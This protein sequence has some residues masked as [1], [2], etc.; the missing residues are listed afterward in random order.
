MKYNQNDPKVNYL[1]RRIGCLFNHKSYYANLQETDTAFKTS[2]MLED[3]TKWKS[4]GDLTQ[5]AT[6]LSNTNISSLMMPDLSRC[7]EE[8]EELE[9]DIKHLLK[10][11]R[12]AMKYHTRFSDSLTSILGTALTCYE[13]NKSTGNTIE[14]ESFKAAIKSSIPDG[15]IFKAFPL[16]T[17]HTNAVSFFELVKNDP[18]G[19]TVVSAAGDQLAFAVRA[20]VVAFPEGVR[21]VWLIVGVHFVEV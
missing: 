13:L 11:Y 21:A 3:Q 6:I 2:L 17:N 8:E 10:K 5:F 9:R 7:I 19:E 15:H 20:K 4:M 12:D 16:Q 1:Y 14:S 18:T